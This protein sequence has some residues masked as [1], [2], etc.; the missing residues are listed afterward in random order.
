M[1]YL[2]PNPFFESFKEVVDITRYDFNKH[3]TAGLCLTTSGNRLFLGGISPSMPA[4]KIPR[5][6]TCIEGTWLIKMGQLV[7]TT[8]KE[9]QD[10]FARC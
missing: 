4:A 9:A 5:W 1:I 6:R 2:S 3:R 10:A 7:V 8:I